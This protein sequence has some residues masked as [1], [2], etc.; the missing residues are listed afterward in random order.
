[1]RIARRLVMHEV[2]LLVSLVLWVARRRQGADGG[3]AFGYARGQGAMMAGFGFVCVVE[4]VAMS[5]LLRDWPTVHAVLLLLDVYGVVIVV[6]L[7][8]SSVVR[9]HVLDVEGGSLRIRRYVHVDLR[10][11]LERIASVRRELRMTHERADGE[12]AVEVGSQTTVTIELT[13]PVTHL[14]FLGRRREVRVVR[15]HADDADGLV[16]ALGRA[17]V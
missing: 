7:H 4:T 6:A 2:R 12:L 14:T 9:P 11:P 8:A 10:V 15:F 13:E 1:M 16:R 3:R 17:R 5:V